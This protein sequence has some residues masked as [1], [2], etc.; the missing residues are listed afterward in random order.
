MATDIEVRSWCERAGLGEVHDVRP[1]TAGRSGSA[2]AAVRSPAGP[3]VVKVTTDPGRL[4]R[5]RREVEVLHHLAEGPVLV[6]PAVLGSAVTAEGVAVALEEGTPLPDAG[7]LT[8]DDWGA[9]ALLVAAVH[10]VPVPPGWEEQVVAGPLPP[11][12]E[13]G[14]CHVDNMVRDRAG[15]V[16][17]VDWQEARLGHGLADLVFVWQRA[18]FAGAHPPREAMTEAYADARGLDRV[19]LAPLLDRIELRLLR[20]EWPPFL[21][22]GDDAGRAALARRLAALTSGDAGPTLPT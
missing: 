13:H 22:L 21:S 14:D 15:R 1:I 8:A 18:E 12:L 16:L 6:A 2:V 3:A 11:V 5:A 9:I 7:R 19:A 10:A 4:A 17:L 20:E